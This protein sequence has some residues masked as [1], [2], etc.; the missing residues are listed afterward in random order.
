MNSEPQPPSERD[1]QLRRVLV[2]TATASTSSAPRRGRTVAGSIVAFALAGAVT[3]GA[4][5][6][7]ALAGSPEPERTSISVAEMMDGVVRDDTQLFGTPFIIRSSGQTDVDLGR[8]PE[9]ATTLALALHCLDP[10]VYEQFLGGQ[11]IGTLTC[12]ESD[13]GFTNGGGAIP[14]ALSGDTDSHTLQIIAEPSQRYV[15]WASWAT[16]A[17]KSEPSTAQ[18]T[19]VADGVITEAEYRDGFARY[20]ACMTDAGYPVVRVDE[21]G[22]IITYS[23]SADSVSSGKEQRCY[24]SEFAQ[25]DGGWQIQQEST[26]E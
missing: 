14:V 17:A 8:A 25:L 21:S 15:I 6:A 13:T 19:A 18:Q 11:S 7:A 3:G 16:P 10:G 5:S 12:T 20:S 1:E 22:A 9:G 23:N 2:A 24:D 4:I 26:L